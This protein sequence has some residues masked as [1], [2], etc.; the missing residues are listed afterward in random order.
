MSVVVGFVG[1]KRGRAALEA[2][3]VEAQ[4][5]ET[6]LVVVHSFQGGSRESGEEIRVTDEELAAIGTRLEREGI[7]HSIHDYV[8]GN[9]SA[10]DLV[11]A[12]REFD[13]ELVV[14]GIRRR[15][16]AGKFLLGSNAHD[17]LMEAECPVLVVK[18]APE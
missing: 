16:A 5:R 7:P 4:R 11:L 12:S 17:I 13:A 15:S 8:R 18:A 3:I 2:A 1:S 10:Q 6:D 9:T 14:I